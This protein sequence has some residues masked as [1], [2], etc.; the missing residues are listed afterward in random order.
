MKVPV[1]GAGTEDELLLQKEQKGVCHVITGN[2]SAGQ[3]FKFGR[4]GCAG[5]KY[6]GFIL[7]DG[8]ALDGSLIE[9]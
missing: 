5:Q 9:K 8:I 4:S 1:A 2:V 6:F 7:T 3:S